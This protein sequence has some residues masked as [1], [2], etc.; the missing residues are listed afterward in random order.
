MQILGISSTILMVSFMVNGIAKDST[1]E[2]WGAIFIIT[3]CVLVWTNLFFICIVS[4]KPASWT[5]ERVSSYSE[6]ASPISSATYGISPSYSPAGHSPKPILRQTRSDSEVIHPVAKSVGW[7]NNNQRTKDRN[8][9]IV[10]RRNSM[11][12]ILVTDI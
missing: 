9:R 1:P 3:S 4:A 8:N 10:A 5:M 12:N 2:Q 6:T 7:E 11:K